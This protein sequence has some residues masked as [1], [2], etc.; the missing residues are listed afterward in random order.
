MT[1]HHRRPAGAA[2]VVRKSNHRRDGQRDDGVDGPGD[3]VIVIAWL[4][5][6]V[7][8]EHPG[9]IDLDRWPERQ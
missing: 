3:P 7:P 2:E 4:C 1:P 5:T 6:N 9:R 8:D